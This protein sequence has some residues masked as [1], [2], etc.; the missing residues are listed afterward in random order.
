MFHGPKRS[1]ILEA[2]HRVVELES[3]NSPGTG[4]TVSV[5]K[6]AGGLASNVVAEQARLEFEIRFWEDAGLR[7]TLRRVKTDIASP[8]VPGCRSTL[9]PLKYRPPLPAN[10]GTERMFRLI[11]HAGRLLGQEIRE[12]HRRGGS[13]ANWLSRAG[14][15]SIDGL[16]PLG[17]LDCTEKEFIITETLFDRIGLTARILLERELWSLS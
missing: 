1:A 16:G 14:I 8:K 13:D 3:L 11:R 9:V 6:V 17:D 10:R 2:A 4:L 15:P 5:G 12:E 7:Q